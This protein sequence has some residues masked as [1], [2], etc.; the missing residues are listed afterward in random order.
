MPRR[1]FP[2]RVVDLWVWCSGFNYAIPL[3]WPWLLNK[4][5]EVLLLLQPAGSKRRLSLK[6]H[7]H[8]IHPPVGMALCKADSQMG[9][10]GNLKG[11]YFRGGGNGSSSAAAPLLL[12]PRAQLYFIECDAHCSF[13]QVLPGW[14][15]RRALDEETTSEAI[16]YIKKNRNWNQIYTSWSSC[17]PP[18]IL[19]LQPRLP[20]C[21]EYIARLLQV[22]KLNSHQPRRPWF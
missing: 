7:P 9:P 19:F 4:F 11:N 1:R 20:I 8:P 6:V 14:G 3:P 15:M 10:P 21:N 2:T 17:P 22:F 12:H 5:G 13:T 16:K 18:H